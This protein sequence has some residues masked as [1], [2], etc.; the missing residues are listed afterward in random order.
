M[1][2]FLRHHALP[3]PEAIAADGALLSTRKAPGG[4]EFRILIARISGT[5]NGTPATWTLQ[6]A[7][8]ISPHT[9]LRRRFIGWL[10]VLMGLCL[11]GAAIAAHRMVAWQLRPLRHFISSAARIDARTLEHRVELSHLPVEIRE[12]GSAFNLMLDRLE[13]SY[14]RLD[15][16]SDNLA[17]ELRTP[18][19]QMMLGLE[20]ALRRDRTPEEYCR[21]LSN[22][23]QQC[24]R[25]VR[26]VESLTFLARA[27]EED[28]RLAMR[29]L[30]AAAEL[31]TVR[32]SF[33]EAARAAGVEVATACADGLC[34]QG[35]STSFQQAI[36]NLMRNALRHTPNGGRITITAARAG[37]GG[38]VIE[39]ADTGEGI[40]PEHLPHLFTRCYFAH[41]GRAAGDDRIGLGL[42]LTKSIVEM[43]GGTIAIDSALGQ[44]T[45]VRIVIPEAREPE[46]H[47]TIYEND[48]S[49]ISGSS[50]GNDAPLS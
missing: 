26:I 9:L 10:V 22:A 37:A 19:S 7:L 30:D 12:L 45:R 16:C 3:A 35:D 41:I 28:V 42:S 48:D 34:F 40:A 21:V 8:D 46:S 15:Q 13:A 32:K 38:I 4:R 6:L 39:V 50:E 17:H 47:Q 27:G 18:V 2:E 1:P 31:E 43:H 36:G 44:G 29:V 20:I 11:L 25:L 23:R 24:Q 5:L 49:V 14:K 33:A